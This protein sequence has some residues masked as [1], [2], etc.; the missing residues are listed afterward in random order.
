MK[1]IKTVAI[2]IIFVSLCM[3]TVNAATTKPFVIRSDKKKLLVKSL[4]ADAKGILTYQAQGFS[5][6][7]KPGR[8]LY[9][10]T[11]LPNSIKDA[12]RK[13]RSKKYRDAVKEFDAA[14]KTNRYLG[15][16]SYCMYYAAKSL[17]ASKKDSEAL[18]RLA[19][20]KKMPLDKE[21]MPWFMKAKQLEA[22][23][24]IKNKK[25][26]KASK[27]L[28]IISKSSDTKSAMFANNAKGDI[29]K[30]EG[31]NSE[32]LFMYMRNVILFNPDKSKESVKAI[33]ET[34]KILKDQKNPQ[35]EE[36][37]KLQ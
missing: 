5:Q 32:A 24:L 13:Y 21:E 25:F 22:D 33:T 1:N 8:Y 11:P 10:R 9:A 28:S 2:L 35:A 17:E 15:W 19:L 26:E 14:F 34:V 30:A 29:L 36:F 12:V 27:V 18:T 37:E 3:T 6:K 16:G 20:L 31:N 4:T 23:I 7:L